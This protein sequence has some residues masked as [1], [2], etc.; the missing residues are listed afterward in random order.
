VK[1]HVL[2]VAVLMALGSRAALAASEG[3]D[4]WSVIQQDQQSPHSILQAAPRPWAEDSA[5]VG[6]EGGDTW[7]R[8]P[9][10]PAG[11]PTRTAATTST[12]MGG[13][14]GSEGGDTWSRF[15]PQPEGAPA[16]TAGIVSDEVI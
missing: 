13:Q 6:S 15:V 9:R 3:G 16:S 10:Q 14:T 12:A 8:F 11:E 2:L 7:S 5:W 1:K 4:T